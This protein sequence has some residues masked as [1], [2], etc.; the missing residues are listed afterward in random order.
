MHR[1]L[2]YVVGLVIAT[3]TA[4]G[5]S[6]VS[7][8][9]TS[10]DYMPL[11]KQ[12]GYET[13]VFDISALAGQKSILALTVREYEGD[14]LVKENALP[15]TPTFS[16]LELLA[17]IPEEYRQSWIDEGLDDPEH[18]IITIARKLTIGFIPAPADS[19]KQFMMSVDRIG[20][21]S[22]QLKLTPVCDPGTG[23]KNYAYGTRPFK[24]DKAPSRGYVPLVLFGSCWYDEKSNCFR[25]CGEKEIDPDLTVEDS[26]VHLIP[27]FYVFGVDIQPV[28]D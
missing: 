3:S 27:H 8:A 7:Q 17:D 22:G 25:F 23:D 12:A 20:S 28:D 5:Q 26:M 14:K 11:L 6:I 9:A 16:N 21:A 15:W 19:L 1:F 18:G 24:L 10:D 4:A 13:Y 2:S